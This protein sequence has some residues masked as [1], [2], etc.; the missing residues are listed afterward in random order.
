M[1]ETALVNTQI[2]DAVTQSN[3]KVVAEAPSLAMATVYQMLGQAVGLT[4]Q[5][6]SAAQNQMQAVSTA[7]I[8]KVVEMIIS[9]SPS[10]GTRPSSFP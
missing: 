6:A 1:A 3:V 4:M 10:S 5:N 7:A 2:T 8:G 9:I